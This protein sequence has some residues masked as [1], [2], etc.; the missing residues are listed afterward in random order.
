ML[1]V[2]FLVGPT[3][4]GKTKLAIDLALKYNAEII[5]ADSR[6]I[7][8]FMS[9]GTAQPNND[10]MKRIKHHFISELLPNQDFNAGQ[11]QQEADKIIT[12]LMQQHKHVIV[13]GGSGLYIS[14]LRDGLSD[15]P[16]DDTIR[17][18]LLDRLKQEGNQ[19]LF[20]ELQN[21]DLPASLTM[22][23]TKSQRLIRALEVYYLTG[24]PISEWQKM[25]SSPI[26]FQNLTIGLNL[27]RDL[28]YQRI[29]KRVDMMINNGLLD[30][31]K[32]LIQLGYNRN[33]NAL[34]TVGYDELFDFL[35]GNNSFEY[36]VEKIKQHSRNYAKRQLTWF[37]RDSKIHWVE[38]D[39]PNVLGHLENIWINFK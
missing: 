20:S 16:K 6:Q 5:S 27:N 24:K 11:F 18:H 19:S 30:E 28:L 31:V 32:N 26:Q 17:N 23:A 22:D 39:Q 14:A 38:V 36:A 12:H 3:A 33:S 10:E 34:K 1:P 37:K 25:P 35:E 15:I 2:L 9:I 8:K 13:V 7:Y 4:V 21:I 29:N